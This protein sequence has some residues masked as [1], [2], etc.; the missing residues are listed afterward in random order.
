MKTFQD[1]SFFLEYRNLHLGKKKICHLC[2]SFCVSFSPV[3]IVY[4]LI[5]RLLWLSP[6]FVKV[7]HTDGTKGQRVP[8]V[9]CCSRPLWAV[10]TSLVLL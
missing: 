7:D 3:R 5:N 4:P 8:K 10:D 9:V 2:F 6:N 1:F